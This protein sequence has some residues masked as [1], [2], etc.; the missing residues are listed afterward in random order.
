MENTAQKFG[1]AVTDRPASARSLP[2]R[3]RRQDHPLHTPDAFHLA[4]AREIQA[5]L[6]VTADRVM[7]NAATA[8]GIGIVRFDAARGPR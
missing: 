7:I 3:R 5:D 6:L 4:I 8:L 2:I 1:C